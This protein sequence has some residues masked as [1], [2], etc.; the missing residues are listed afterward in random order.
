MNDQHRL[1]AVRTAAVYTAVAGLWIVFSDKVLLLLAQD[2]A[3]I[4]A[5]QTAK[6]WFFVLAT[7]ALLYFLVARDLETIGRSAAELR[8]RNEALAGANEELT[9]VEEELRQ[10]FNELIANQAKIFR[11]NECLHTLRETAFALMHERDVDSLLRLI[12]EKA[13]AI[14]ESSH[15][16]LYTL[17]PDEQYME[18]RIVIGTAIQEIGF[19]QTRDR[20]VVGHVWQTGRP[21]VVHDYHQWPERIKGKGFSVIRTSTGF[22]LVVGGKVV[23]VFGVNYFDHHELPESDRDLLASF[24][25]LASI[26]L[27]NVRLHS[28]LRA[29]LAERAKIETDLQR[30][31]TRTQALLDAIPD[32]ILRFSLD[33]VLLEQKKGADMRT[34]ASFENHIGRHIDEFTPAD[35]ADKVTRSMRE[36]AATRTTQQFEYEVAAASG[37][38]YHRE[39]RVVADAAGEA[40][41]I[42]RDITRRREMEN[43]LKHM[44]LTDQATGLNNRV[45]FENELRRLDD[46]RYLPLGVIVCDIDGLKFIND[47]LGRDSGDKLIAAAAYMIAA[48]C[49][50]GAVVA[51]IGGGE[52]GIILANTTQAAVEE[53]CERIRAAVADYRDTNKMP[54]SVSVG[55]SLC[56]D[57]QTTLNDTF[58]TADRNMYR[59]K[60]HSDQSG[61]SAIVNTL[62]Q[63]LEARDFVTDGHADRLQDLMERLAVAAGFPASALPDLRLLGRFH[64]IGKVGIP[65]HILFKP[66]RLTAEEFAVMKRHCEIGYRIAQASPEL[67]P[68]AD[69]I[70]KHQ[71]WWNGQGYPLGLAGEDIPLPCRMLAIVDAYDAMTNDRPYRKAMTGGEAVAEL[72]RCAG[73]QFDDRLV[74][75]FI[76]I[77]Q[78]N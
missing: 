75:L 77:I 72:R 27:D 9:A 25:E 38:V 43:E 29:E 59:E 47:T 8:E 55:M 6:G 73:R 33:G 54:L 76:T 5:L 23:G 12:V 39:M 28:A 19:R 4:T 65:D 68:I 13:A 20:G 14:G 18:L 24:A 30:Q 36:A 63:A 78:R 49:G 60:L 45:F 74:G 48:C 37:V 22:P 11:Q 70:L 21:I 31:Q 16:Y 35:I 53:T 58:K 10:Q 15:A 41:G 51:R 46:A 52:Y 61:H 69:W 67:A 7:A 50:T 26:A 42:I 57:G 2:G 44:G 56:T 32:V 64:D 34:T 66:G 17:T 3:A 40:I 62:A 71:E 1:A